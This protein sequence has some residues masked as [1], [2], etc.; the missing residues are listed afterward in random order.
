MENKSKI[1]NI[2]SLILLVLLTVLFGLTLTDNPITWDLL[3]GNAILFF[4]LFFAVPLVLSIV[5]LKSQKSL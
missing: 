3:P 4:P 5:S 1:L 2:I